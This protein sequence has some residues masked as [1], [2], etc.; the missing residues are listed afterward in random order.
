MVRKIIASLLCLT[1][2]MPG[3]KVSAL[4][5][6]IE[7][8]SEETGITNSESSFTIPYNDAEARVYYGETGINL[9]TPEGNVYIP[10]NYGVLKLISVGDVDGDGYHDFLSYQSVPAQVAQLLCLSGADGHVISTV[11]LTRLGYDDNLTTNIDVNCFI[12]QM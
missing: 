11:R 1:L 7:E 4:E 3:F 2:L 9:F 12:Q 8:L 10:T 5:K 6:S